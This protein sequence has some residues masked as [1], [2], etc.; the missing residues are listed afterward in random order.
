MGNNFSVE[1]KEFMKAEVKIKHE[2]LF[3]KNIGEVFLY[4]DFNANK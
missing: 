3:S 1:E 2:I 4:S